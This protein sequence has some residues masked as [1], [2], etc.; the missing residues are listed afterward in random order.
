MV[1]KLGSPAREAEGF[2]RAWL[3]STPVSRGYL[4]RAR[5]VRLGT[6]TGD[7]QNVFSKTT[8]LAASRSNAGVRGFGQL[9]GAT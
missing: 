9:T 8:P 6:Q 4:P 5:L 1:I 2:A 7:W 3:S